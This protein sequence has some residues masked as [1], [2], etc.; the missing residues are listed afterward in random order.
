MGERQCQDSCPGSSL[1]RKDA[2]PPGAG[3]G[4]AKLPAGA[5]HLRAGQ[6]PGVEGQAPEAS[7]MRVSTQAAS[8]RLRKVLSCGSGIGP[9]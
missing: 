6:R 5:G 1:P 7:R 3:V 8:S 4:W 2:Q 9:S